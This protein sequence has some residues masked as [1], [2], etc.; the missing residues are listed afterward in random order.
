MFKRVTMKGITLEDFAYLVGSKKKTLENDK[1][2]L[3]RIARENKGKKIKAT[4]EQKEDLK[5]MRDKKIE[6]EKRKSRKN[7]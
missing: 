2:Y 3:F 4:K 5:A 6:R 1:E 7:Q